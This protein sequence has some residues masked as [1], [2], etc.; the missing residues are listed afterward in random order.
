MKRFFLAAAL[1]LA[2]LPAAAQQSEPV[3]LDASSM[4]LA[5]DHVLITVIFRQDQSRPLD[6]LI[7]QMEETGF[8]SDFPPEGIEPVSWLNVM[9]FGQVA[10]FAV[11]PS[12]LR[13]FNVAIERHAWGPYRTEVYATYDFLDVARTIHAPLAN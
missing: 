5:D 8:L 10:T 13:E 6:D 9:G 4:T 7:A 11:P 12:R 1:T 2:I 3:D